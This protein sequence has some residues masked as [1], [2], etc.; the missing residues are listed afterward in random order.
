MKRLLVG[1]STFLLFFLGCQSLS[2]AT[3]RPFVQNW[4]EKYNQLKGQTPSEESCQGFKDLS[5]QKFD[6]SEFALLRGSIHCKELLIP[7]KMSPWLT[8]EWSEVRLALAESKSSTEDL[9]PLLIDRSKFSLRTEEKVKL[10][11]RALQ[12]AKEE[13]RSEEEIGQIT[14]RLY[15]LA[16]RFNK[17][18]SFD[19]SLSVAADFQRARE[20]QEARR[21]YLKVLNSKKSSLIQQMK[22]FEAIARIEKLLHN[23]ED[24]VSK[25]KLYSAFLEKRLNR[26]NLKKHRQR[27]LRKIQSNEIALIRALWTIGKRSE[28]EKILEKRISSKPKLFSYATHYWLLGRI[29]EEKKEFENSLKWLRLSIK[30]TQE[31]SELES[32]ARWFL[33]WNLYKNKDYQ[34]AI[35]VLLWFKES[36]AEEFSKSRSM[37]WIGVSHQKLDNENLANKTFTE[38]VDMDPLGYYGLLARREL[39]LPL[40][41]P[42]LKEGEGSSYFFRRKV[43]KVFQPEWVEWMVRMK[44]KKSLQNYMAQVTEEYEKKKDQEDE[45]WLVLLKSYARAGEY[46]GLF[47]KLY[48]L[49][50]ETRS[51]LLQDHP[52]LLFPTPYREEIEAAASKNEIEPELIYSIIRQESAFNE[53]ARSPADAF[54]LM[55]LLPRVGTK[56]GKKI[57]IKV[58]HYTDLFEP[59]VNISLGAHLI[60]QQRKR[61]SGEFI[62]SIAS[63]NASESAIRGW[64]KSRHRESALEFIEEIP[65]EET[66]G[67]VR[68]IIRNF[69]FYRL[70]LSPQKETY[71]PEVL[72]STKGSSTAL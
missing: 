49:S 55:Q 11:E 59:Q 18:Y 36:K 60:S 10:V 45:V 25:L 2:P 22:A 66:K 43:R 32:Q 46:L 38:L 26:K 30:E 28:A 24:H 58:D 23:K 70:F 53:E 20:F 63:Y 54:G 1:S 15:L 34:E 41:K 9:V 5:Q 35:D 13:K 21:I 31:D 39:S 62:S 65:Y 64:K 67:Y 72:L 51:R 71:F 56:I 27:L 19:E 50:P 68:L 40:R 7:E 42:E 47:K 57:G 52:E 61:F 3:S 69:A 17:D 29:A 48:E 4:I 8:E 12:I 44:E 16:P 14:D 6:L 37:Y 33:A